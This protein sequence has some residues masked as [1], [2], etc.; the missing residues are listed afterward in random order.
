MCFVILMVLFV[1]VPKWKLWNE[2]HTHTQYDIT[3]DFIRRVQWKW[4]RFLDV[5]FA[6]DVLLLLLLKFGFRDILKK[7]DGKWFSMAIEYIHECE[8][9]KH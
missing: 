3:L 1:A 4:S 9:Y 5:A 2:H 6:V 8:A 7:D